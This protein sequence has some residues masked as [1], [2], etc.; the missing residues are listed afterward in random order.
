[1]H[2]ILGQLLHEIQLQNSIKTMGM[3]C[4]FPT[5]CLI[6][7]LYRCAEIYLKYQQYKRHHSLFLST[8]I[9]QYDQY[10]IIFKCVWKKVKSLISFKK[11][12]TISIWSRHIQDWPKG[13]QCTLAFCCKEQLPFKL[14]Q[15]K[16][17]L[18]WTKNNHNHNINKNSW[19]FVFKK[20]KPKC[21]FHRKVFFSSFFSARDIVC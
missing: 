12:N 14:W 16:S 3:H 11:L 9:L 7:E 13:I 1:M 10:F 20:K 4:N 21:S 5:L 15:Q 8:F 6:T 17:G 2:C 18:N 19:H